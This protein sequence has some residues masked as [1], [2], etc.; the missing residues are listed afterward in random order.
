MLNSSDYPALEALSAIVET[1][2]F[3]RAADRLGVTSGAVSQRLKGLE[4][5]IGTLLVHRQ[6]PARPTDTGARLVR[7]FSEVRALEAGL[8]GPSARGTPPLL[9]IAVTADAMATWLLP[10]FTAVPDW[11]FDFEIDDQDHSETWLQ[12]GAVSAALTARET[13]LRGC[14]V[15]DLG[16]MRYAAVASPDFVARWFEGGITAAT[17]S[18]AP[19]LTFN[20][21]DDLQR[22]WGRLV[23][24]QKLTLRTH[25]LPSTQDITAAICQ[26]LGWGLNP[27]SCLEDFID[28]GRL[29]QLTSTLLET[30]LY[31]QVPRLSAPALAP[32]TT[33][34]RSA[35]R[36]A[37]QP[38]NQ[39]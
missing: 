8:Q 27:L 17:L 19:A 12:T 23:T 34:I 14:D 3:D 26:G 32:L 1:G 35:A 6:S 5:R 39:S 31:W 33:A 9:R 25:Y 4:D 7:H 37:L 22:R 11:L 28:A 15:H 38:T 24:G 18:A 20:R 10:A 30:P 13:P 36:Q 16:A 29:I 2:S 21:K